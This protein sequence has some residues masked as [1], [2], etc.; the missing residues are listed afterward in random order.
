LCKAIIKQ[1]HLQI[2][3]LTSCLIT[4]ISKKDEVV[5]AKDMREY[6]G[7]RSITPDI[8]NFCTRSR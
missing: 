2:F 3:V 4:D 6:R 8:L 7:R 1:K 5:S